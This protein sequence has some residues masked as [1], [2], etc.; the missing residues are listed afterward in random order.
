MKKQ[1]PPKGGLCY[2]HIGKTRYEAFFHYQKKSTKRSQCTHLS[3]LLSVENVECRLCLTAPVNPARH[4]CLTCPHYIYAAIIKLSNSLRILNSLR[5]EATALLIAVSYAICWVLI[6]G[7]AG[8]S[9]S[10]RFEGSY[11]RNER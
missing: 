10:F 4:N 2:T 5:R 6:K 7:P 8:H 9:E 3:L 1:G 11:C